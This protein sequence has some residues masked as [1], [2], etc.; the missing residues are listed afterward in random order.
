MWITYMKDAFYVVFIEKKTFFQ[1]K[2]YMGIDL[3]QY[4]LCI[5]NL[6]FRP[7]VGLDCE[8]FTYENCFITHPRNQLNWMNQSLNCAEE[9]E[10]ILSPLLLHYK[11]H[12]DTQRLLCVKDAQKLQC[13]ANTQ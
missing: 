11:C 5:Q 4:A 10:Q 13:T 3:V 8:T 2:K 9:N 7:S 12:H 6:K 1:I